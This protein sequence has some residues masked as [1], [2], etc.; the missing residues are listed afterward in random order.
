MHFP[1]LLNGFNSEDKLFKVSLATIRHAH[2]DSHVLAI[3]NSFYFLR[4]RLPS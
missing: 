1:F 3:S 4:G 2:F